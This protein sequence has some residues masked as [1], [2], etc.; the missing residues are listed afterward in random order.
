[1]IPLQRCLESAGNPETSPTR[2]PQSTLRKPFRA[3][4]AKTGAAWRGVLHAVGPALGWAV[5][6]AGCVAERPVV[7]AGAEGP[8]PEA[9]LAV[10]N[11]QR[12]GHIL[13]GGEVAPAGLEDLYR[14]GV[15]TI[16][17]VRNEPGPMAAEAERAR[18]L[19][20]NYVAV[21]MVSNAMTA[22]QARAILEAM[23]RHKKGDVLIHCG[24]GNRAAGA[25]G[26]YLGATGQ[27]PVQEALERAKT[28]GLRNDELVRA[29]RAHLTTGPSGETTTR[30]S[31]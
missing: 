4:P 7:R 10:K 12:D 8:V 24:S 27:C 6:L 28:A 30:P 19:G 1:M 2:K 29:V 23:S 16:I 22:E 25:Y 9:G 15:R 20:M 14:A 18:P 26:L 5:S 3:R 31:Q 11:L 21:P 17:D 13:I